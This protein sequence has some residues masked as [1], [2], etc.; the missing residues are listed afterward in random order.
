MKL[1]VDVYDRATP[2]ALA[3]AA[4]HSA[5][6]RN[7]QLAHL[8]DLRDSWRTAGY[9]VAWVA[10]GVVVAT[11]DTMPLTVRWIAVARDS[12]THYPMSPEDALGVVGSAD[13]AG[14]L[15]RTMSGYLRSD[16]DEPQPRPS[17]ALRRPTQGART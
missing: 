1:T 4:S 9:L 2:D 7:R 5:L 10:P 15:A 6:D 16:T 11:D 12:D 3:L 17:L 13:P 8:D 14:R